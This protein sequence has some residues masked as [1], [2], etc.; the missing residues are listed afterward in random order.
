M[1]ATMSTRVIKSGRTSLHFGEFKLRRRPLALFRAGQRVDL[2]AQPLRLLELLAAN[3]GRVVSH[4]EIHEALWKDRTVSFAGSTHVSIRRIRAALGD[5]AGAPRFIETAPGAG[6]RFIARVEPDLMRSLA[7][8]AFGA[9]LAAAAIFAFVAVTRDDAVTGT[10]PLEAVR[11]GEYLLMQ[12]EADSAHRSLAY[13]EGAIAIAP[14]DVRALTGAAR[15]ALAVHDYDRAEDFAGRILDLQSNNASGL[16]VRGHVAMMRDRDWTLARRDIDAALVSDPDLAQAHHSMA[17]LLVLSGAFDGAL[18]HMNLARQ[19]DPASTLVH[20]DLGWMQY[21]ARHF[22][23][24]AET[25]EQAVALEPDVAAFRYC[26]IRA[27][28]RLGD[29]GRARPHID[30]V[31]RRSDVEASEIEAALNS[32]DP[33]GSFD[34]WRY[35]RYRAPH[36]G[37]AVPPLVLAFAAILAGEDDAALEALD[38]A[39]AAN[40]PGAGFAFVDPAFDPLIGQ[41]RYEALR[42]ILTPQDARPVE[43]TDRSGLPNAPTR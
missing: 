25:C 31:M 27:S 22:R 4:A 3:A 7:P 6:Y 38:R 11:L 40:D 15:A 5:E 1:M 34:R 41:P 35:D 32:G 13:F 26:V 20:A 14:E 2:T 18:E 16:E 10:S 23:E 37:Q 19:L 17:T 36:R 39:A 28:E 29:A 24:A 9:S 30:W 42:A 12:T 8:A 43:I 33:V 21:Y